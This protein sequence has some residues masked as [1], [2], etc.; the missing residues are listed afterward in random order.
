MEES[1]PLKRSNS[2]STAKKFVDVVQNLQ[3]QKCNMHCQF[4]F[5]LTFFFCLRKLE[6]DVFQKGTILKLFLFV[7]DVL[8]QFATYTFLSFS[9]DLQRFVSNIGSK[10]TTLWQAIWFRTFTRFTQSFVFYHFDESLDTNLIHDVLR[11]FSKQQFTQIP[12]FRKKVSWQTNVFKHSLSKAILKNTLHRR[13]EVSSKYIF[14]SAHSCTAPDILWSY[15]I[16]NP[17]HYLQ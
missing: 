3:P 4:H 16:H 17:S 9:H 14:G 2:E 7:F 10:L 8:K 6:F 12:H 15:E 5:V 13:C 1:L 11:Q